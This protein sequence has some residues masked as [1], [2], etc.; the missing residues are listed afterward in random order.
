ML[1]PCLALLASCGARGTAPAAPAA[2]PGPAASLQD[3]VD[4]VAALDVFVVTGTPAT[5]D[6]ERLSRFASAARSAAAGASG[7]VSDM[8]TCPDLEKAAAEA[9]ADIS[10]LQVVDV[11]EL[12]LEEWPS[13]GT[14]Y[15]L[16]CDEADREVEARNCDRRAKAVAIAKATRDL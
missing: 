11:A 15:H 10:S 16:P 8:G 9:L 6:A 13:Q 7:D 5:A 4:A 1:V 2:D 3:S 14:C 12:A